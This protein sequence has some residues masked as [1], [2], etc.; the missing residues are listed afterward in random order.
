MTVEMGRFHKMGKETITCFQGCKIRGKIADLF[1]GGNNF[2]RGSKRVGI[3]CHFA[4]RKIKKKKGE[5]RTNDK[6]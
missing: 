2:I 6:L 5:K 1:A 4:K 3:P